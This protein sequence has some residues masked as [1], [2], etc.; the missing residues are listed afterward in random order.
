M[1]KGL[2]RRAMT[3][4]IQ[5]KIRDRKRTP[6]QTARTAKSGDRIN[7][8]SVGWGYDRDPCQSGK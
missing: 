7:H 4:P 3:T 1:R 6:E 8:G 5:Q 2:E